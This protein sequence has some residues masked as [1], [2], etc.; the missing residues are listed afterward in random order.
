MLVL[1]ASVLLFPLECIAVL[2]AASSVVLPQ[3]VA[4]MTGL[5]A[6]EPVLL[7]LLVVSGL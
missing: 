5:T 1:P 4:V 2:R 6:A 7:L 3:P